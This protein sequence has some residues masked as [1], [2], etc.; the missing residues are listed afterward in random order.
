[1]ND[2]TRRTIRTALAVLVA[3]AAAAPVLV[4]EAGLDADQWPWLASVLA[5]AAVI[6]RLMASPVVDGILAKLGLGKAPADGRHE[7][8]RDE[9]GAARLWLVLP[10]VII[11]AAV[12]SLVAADSASAHRPREVVRSANAQASALSV[13][14]DVTS[15]EV[16]AGTLIVTFSGALLVDAARYP[17][18]DMGL[19]KM[20]AYELSGRSWP[21]GQWVPLEGLR[22]GGGHSLRWVGWQDSVTKGSHWVRVRVRDAGTVSEPFT[23]TTECAA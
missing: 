14:M 3:L 1:M 6:T 13:D 18:L 20:E 21:H 22:S 2:S 17:I 16:C 15:T 19:A 10:V 4:S 8:G 23:I 7:L 5:V 11:L 9:V 12:A